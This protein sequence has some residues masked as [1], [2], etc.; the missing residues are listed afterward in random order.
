MN[1]APAVVRSR[2]LFLAAIGFAVAI[3]ILLTSFPICIDRNGVQLVEFAKRMADDPVAAMKLTTRQPAYSWLLLQTHRLIG[4]IAG[5]DTPEAWQRCGELIALIGGLGACVAISAVARR[6]FDD[7]IAAVAAVLAACWP[8]GVVLSAGVLSDM[9]HLAAFL[10]AML[11]IIDGCSRRS[12]GRLAA[13]GAV[14]GI[15]YL[16]KQEAISLFAGG[17]IAWWLSSRSEPIARRLGGAAG[18][19]VVFAVVISPHSLATGA[20]IPNKNPM[21]ILR[22]VGAPQRG[23]GSNA[24]LAYVVPWWQTPGRF[25]EDW[26]RS[27]RYVIP[28]L[29]LAGILLKQSAIARREGRALIVATVA[30]YIVLIQARSILYGEISERYAA[31]PGVLAIPW[32]AA[33]WCALADRLRARNA[34]WATALGALIL[35]PLVVYSL[36]GIT[37]PKIAY[38]EAGARLRAAAAAEDRVLAHEHLE[39]I[40]FYAGRTYP[41]TT[42]IKCLR[43]DASDRIRRYIRGKRPAWYVDAES[44]HRG[45]LDETRHFA[46]LR[47]ANDQFEP[48]IETGRAGSRVVVY[49]IRQTDDKR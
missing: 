6:L 45:E 12:I 25:F 3:R 7:R 1:D 22:L 19:A 10:A 27:G 46:W 35:L 24:I 40:M 11:L 13:G 29:F 26:L 5:G 14:L 44:T 31:I 20:L 23:D 2:P 16:F 17:L 28:L 33:G 4:P 36:R 8:Q 49:R 39:Q 38:R 21:D 18:F 30:V 47:Q 48:L 9:P 34:R 37:A 15:A 41:D 43:S 42:W 32:S